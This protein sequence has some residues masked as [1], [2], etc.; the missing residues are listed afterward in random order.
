MARKTTGRINLNT[1]HWCRRCCGHTTGDRS[2]DV[3]GTLRKDPQDWESFKKLERIKIEDAL[4]GV[5]YSGR[6]VRARLWGSWDIFTIWHFN[7]GGT[8]FYP[9]T[10]KL[11]E[12]EFYFEFEPFGD[13]SLGK[14]F[15]AYTYLGEYLANIEEEDPNWYRVEV[16][17]GEVVDTTNY[18]LIDY[19]SD[20]DDDIQQQLEDF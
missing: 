7:E 10:C 8:A 2:C 4:K 19:L 5:Y 17:N 12:R 9:S 13:A 20:N 1:L 16:V 6:V 11:D 14:P 3:C 18:R 15:D